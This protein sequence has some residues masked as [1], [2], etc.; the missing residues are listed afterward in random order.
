MPYLRCG[1]FLL[2]AY[3]ELLRKLLHQLILQRRQKVNRVLA[4]SPVIT[5]LH[6]VAIL[7]ALVVP[8]CFLRGP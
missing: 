1:V 2:L 7:H 8:T 5:Y 4:V 3:H 6:G